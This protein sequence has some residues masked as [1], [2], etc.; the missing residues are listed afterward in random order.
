M[1]IKLRNIGMLASANIKINGITVV[2]G[3]NNTGKSTIGKALYAIYSCFY[4]INKKVNDSRLEN[5]E[6]I[7]EKIADSL[8]HRLSQEIIFSFRKVAQEIIS[9][10]EDYKYFTP[11]KLR[12][13]IITLFKNFNNINELTYSQKSIDKYAEKIV[14][15]LN[16]PDSS[17]LDKLLEKILNI[18]FNDQIC[19]VFSDNDGEITFTKNN[20]RVDVSVKKEGSVKVKKTSNFL[21]VSDVIYI[22]DPFILNDKLRIFWPFFE[23]YLEHRTSL[24]MKLFPQDDDINIFNEIVMNDKLNNIYKKISSVCT[25][26]II[27]KKSDK[28]VYKFNNTNVDINLQN[29]SAGLKTFVILKTLLTHNVLGFN[30][31]LILDEPEIHLHPQWQLIFAELIVLLQKDI[32]LNILLNTHSPYFLNAIEVYAAKHGINHKCTYYLSSSQKNIATLSNVSNNIDKIYK[33]LARPLQ[34]LENE[35]Y[36]L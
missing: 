5:I 23:N 25:G 15:I 8:D 1:E 24:K 26:N 30:S 14:E 21:L 19:N 9:K 20:E 11:V 33:E 3:K 22:D 36:N 35:E 13:R 17:F 18:E 28:W 16:V 29:L 2:A 10:R 31:V 34:D 7:I 32:D 12:E 27:K 4:N 6:N